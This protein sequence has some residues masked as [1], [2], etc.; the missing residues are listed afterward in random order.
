MTYLVYLGWIWSLLAL[1]GSLDGLLARPLLKRFGISTPETPWFAPAFA[2]S[3]LPGLGQFFNGQ[4]L[5]ALFLAAWPF[6]TLFGYPIRR[7]WQMLFIKSP[8][9]LFP[10]WAVAVAD[11]LL[12]ASL[13]YRSRQREQR[14]AAID[15][16]RHTEGFYDFLDR[17]S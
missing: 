8:F 2:S 13:A 9:L 17:R 1:M 7:P 12:I 6:L 10:W 5:K 11:A 14:S 16:Q 3:M 15:A 4:P